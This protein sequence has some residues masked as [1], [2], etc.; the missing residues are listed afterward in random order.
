MSLHTS[1]V[2]VKADARGE[3]NEVFEAFGYRAIDAAKAHSWD[4][5]IEAMRD[6]EKGEPETVTKK[7][8]V[9]DHGWTVILDD[10][11]VMFSDEEAC[12]AVARRFDAPVF[13]MCCEGI[14]A[15][16]AFTFFNPDLQR[17]LILG[18]GEVSDDRGAPLPEESGIDPAELF[19]TDVLD[20]MQRLGFP[21]EAL[22]D[23][24]AVDVWKVAFEVGE[25]LG[26][27]PIP[28]P[29]PTPPAQPTAPPR[30]TAHFPSVSIKP[31]K[32]WWKIW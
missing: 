16:Y 32:P 28:P 23:A 11:M 20:I 7:P 13:G 31:K 5:A 8:A 21:F 26:P 19:E 2:M 6:R 9:F 10:E 18:D 1:L 14:S 25:D 29:L 15:T 27:P 30:G 3:M 4:A 22:E 17:S 12:S 24:T